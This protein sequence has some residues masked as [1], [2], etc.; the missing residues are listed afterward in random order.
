MQKLAEHEVKITSLIIDGNWQSIDY[1]G[2][3]QF[4]YAWLELEADRKAFPNGLKAM[5]SRIRQ[6]HPGIQHIAV[7]HAL[8]GYWGGISP[9][10]RIDQ[11][12]KTIDV[13]ESSRRRNLPLDSSMTVV[14]KED[15]ERFYDDFTGS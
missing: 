8:L 6:Q 7:W 10:G 2:N 12:Y 3:G 4:Q 5:V 14:A 13:R 15:V 1:K 11:T 9:G